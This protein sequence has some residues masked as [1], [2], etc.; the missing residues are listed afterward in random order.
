MQYSRLLV[1]ITETDF[2]HFKLYH[3]DDD[4]DGVRLRL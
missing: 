4:A 2:E 3:Y 1:F